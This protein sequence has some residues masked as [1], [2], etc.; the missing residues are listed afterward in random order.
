[1]KAKTFYYEDELNDD[2][3]QTVNKI[4]PLPKNYKYVKKGIIPSFLTFI[5]YDVIVRQ[6]AFL[7][8]KIR[9]QVKIKNKKLLKKIKSGYF[10]YINHVTLVGDAFMPNILNFS[11]KNYIITGAQTNSL[12][13]ILPLLRSLGSIPLP[14]NYSQCKDMLSCIKKRINQNSSITIYPEKHVWP[15]Y[16]KIRPFD[17]SSFKY[18]VMLD[19]PVVSITTCFSKKKIGKRPKITLYVDGPFYPQ[20]DLNVKENTIYLRNQVYQSM[21]KRSQENSTYS[22]H[23][24]I[25]K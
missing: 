5:A 13:P 4:R 9:F 19:S 14:D 1:M 21:Q 23:N 25:K 20:K 8:V 16:T 22:V 11:N 2:F 18:P 17:E 6:I 12:K 10:M 15:Y 24:Y 7:Y 3:A